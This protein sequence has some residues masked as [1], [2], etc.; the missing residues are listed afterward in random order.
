MFDAYDAE[1]ISRKNNRLKRLIKKADFD[2]G[3]ACIADI[4]YSAGRKLK[5][6]QIDGLTTCDYIDQKHNIIIMGAS[7]SGNYAKLF[8][9]QSCG[10][11]ALKNTTI[12]FHN[13]A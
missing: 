10:L 6:S 3:Y 11:N 12:P 8:V 9:M 5:K 1:Y 7:G 2:Q 4:N 13:F